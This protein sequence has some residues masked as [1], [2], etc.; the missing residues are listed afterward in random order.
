MQCIFITHS[1][2]TKPNIYNNNNKGKTNIMYN[3][4]KTWIYK[5]I[6]FIELPSLIGKLFNE[7][8]YSNSYLEIREFQFTPLCS[9]Q[10]QPYTNMQIKMTQLLRYFVAVFSNWV[11]LWNIDFFFLFKHVLMSSS[12]KWKFNVCIFDFHIKWCNNPVRYKHFLLGP[13][14]IF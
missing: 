12:S 6:L 5:K 2:C 14:I 7:H 13:Q 9:N 4:G 3:V 8:Q 1:Y 10:L 11:L